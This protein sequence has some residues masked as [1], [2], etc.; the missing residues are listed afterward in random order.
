MAKVI[1][2]YDL[3]V[4]LNPTDSAT[5]TAGELRVSV[6]DPKLKG[7][8]DGAER[9]VVTE[10]QTQTLSN[11][12]ID[13]SNT[14]EYDNTD[15]GLTASNIQDAIDEVQD[16]LEAHIDDSGD[17]HDASAISFD[18]VASDLVATD[19]Q[20]AI[21]EVD[22]RIDTI[23]TDVGT[24]EGKIDDLVTLSGVAAN[25]ED[26]GTFTG[27]TIVDN[28]TVKSA[29]QAL[30]TEVEQKIE[31]ASVDTLTN[32]SIDADTN[33]ITNID[34]NDIKASAGID[35]SKIANGDVSN[36]EF[37]YLDGVTSGI[38]TQFNNITTDLNTHTGSTSGVHG[39][40]G[41][42]VGT[43]D[44]QTL[45]NKTLTGSNIQTPVRLDV[46]QDTK[47][48]LETYALTATNGQLVFATDEKQMF[49]VVDTELVSV[50]GAGIIKVTAGETLVL[51]D[52]V[53]VSTGTGN[54]T[55]RTSGRVY[56]ADASNDDRI[57]VLGFIVKAGD[58]GDTVEVQTSGILKGFTGL[59][60]GKIYFLSEITPGA[61]TNTPPSANG[62]WAI[63]ICNTVSSD[64]IVI[65][66]VPSASAN[67]ISDSDSTFTINNNESS[68]V[69]VTGF[70]VDPL[71]YS[72]AFINYYLYRQTDTG[73]SAVAQSGELVLTFNTQSNIWY[74]SDTPYG[75]TAGVTFSIQPSGQVRYTSTDI[76]GTNYVGTLKINI[77]KA[78]NT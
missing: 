63:S 10:D 35:A 26:L 30:E 52:V 34:N 31:A 21:D 54:D 56:K 32:K 59:D 75:Q 69:D 70:L 60:V 55:G 47:A 3:G 20:A 67:Y 74:I 11:K 4:K 15:S 57:E 73:G 8:M 27:S 62:E 66:P 29:L 6:T 12:T 68:A 7:Y 39:V 61:I 38:Q 24:A 33:T 13:D 19:V 17:A 16:N 1:K 42:I 45:T 9:S 72:S 43:T 71:L 2:K 50:G 77:R 18:N 25:S 28:S 23:E 51:R 76:T 78:F 48:N 40:T 14:I 36:T 41:S 44:I 46:K 37:Q 5:T 58:N 65:N 22:G 49:Q 53:Y 64:T